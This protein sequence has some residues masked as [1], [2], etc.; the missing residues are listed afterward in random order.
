V[1]L[2]LVVA[3]LELFRVF[4][5]GHGIVR[6]IL[7]VGLG[8]GA[9]VVLARAR[10]GDAPGPGPLLL[11]PAAVVAFAVNLVAGVQAIAHT[12]AVHEI[13]MD[14][15]QNSYRAIQYLRLGANP[16][17]RTAMLDPVSYL[18]L[19][20]R[21]PR[22]PQC[23]VRPMPADAM[24]AASRYWSN[25]DPAATSA[26]LPVIGDA[27]GCQSLKV[28]SASLGYKYGPALL[29]AY[30]PFVVG[31]D[32][33]GVFVA[34][35]VFFLLATAL[36]AWFGR[37]RGSSW[38]VVAGALLLFLA[39]SHLRHNVLAL[40][41][42]DLGPTLAAVAAVTFLWRGRDGWAAFFIGLSLAC[43]VLPGLL[44]VPLLLL[45]RRRSWAVFLAPIVATFTPF[46]VW[47][48]QGFANNILFN[49]RRPTDATALAHF[50]SRPWLVAVQAVGL[51]A[52]VFALHR[53]RKQRWTPPAV[54][55]YLWVAHVAVL[56]GGTVFH[57][58]YLVWLLPLLSL[59]FV[60]AA[61]A[62]RTR[63]VGSDLTKAAS[64]PAPGDDATT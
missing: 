45:C 37:T 29:A 36:L 60:V 24:A 61:G 35:V 17:A 38:A 19:A 33:P 56:A 22:Q 7:V 41:A 58:N 28:E 57:N 1:G 39:P 32:K 55:A 62:D 3:Y 13:E 43:K 49:L 63:G 47:D 46:C 51:A 59:T 16:Y 11:V 54:L 4:D 12:A 64:R 5:W 10:R 9:L 53:A 34:H 14:Q 42:S 50:L 52:M 26:I 30:A 2:L 15:G 6:A 21:L 40:S 20:S 48:G 31:F 27:P 25:V 18:D 8:A 23:L 44:Y